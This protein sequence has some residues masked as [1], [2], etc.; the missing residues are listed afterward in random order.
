MQINSTAHTSA[1]GCA[2]GEI[3][4]SQSKLIHRKQT[5]GVRV[6]DFI[7]ISLLR[8]YAFLEGESADSTKCFNISTHAADQILV[9]SFKFD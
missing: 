7:R 3:D 4:D 9:T 5:R 1:A 2:R 8:I 6:T